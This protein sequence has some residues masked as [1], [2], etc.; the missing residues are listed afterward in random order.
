[1][2]KKFRKQISCILTLIFFAGCTVGPDFLKPEPPK[3]DRYTSGPELKSTI[4][5]DGK[6]Q[7][8]EKGAEVTSEWWS[9]FNSPKLNEIVKTAIQKNPNLEAAQASLRQSQDFLRAGYGVFYPHL[10]ADFQATRQ[11]FSEARFGRGPSSKTFNLYTLT[12]TISY[13]LDIFGGQRR[14][15]ESLKANVD[16]EGYT[17]LGTYLTLTA[18]VVNT[19]IARAAY[20]EEI[21]ATE[22]IINIEKEETLLTEVQA[23]AGTV[24]Y[25]NV[26]GLQSQV[27]ATE[28]TLPGLHQKAEQADHLLSTLTG[29]LPVEWTAPE[30]LLSEINLP[31]NLPLSLPSL[32][33]RQRPDVL[34]AEARLHSASAQ[35]GVA[36]AAML[37]SF[38]INGSYGLVATA[39]NDLFKSSSEIWSIG[40][41]ISAPLFHGGELLNKKRAAVENYNFYLASYRQTVLAAFAQVADVLAALE[42]DA[43][44]LDAQARALKSSEESVRIIRTNYQAGIVNYLQVI[45]AYDQYIRAKIAFLQT[46]AQ[47]LQD[48]VALYVALGGGWWNAPGKNPQGIFDS[49][50]EKKD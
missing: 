24:P 19:L 2:I 16:T 5:A 9:F 22:E 43:E 47:R 15:V 18:N 26:L 11:K 13:A 28:A 7:R 4:T 46:R 6:A 1:M 3:V 39:L 25:L 40:G 37:P 35:I 10:D 44:A 17:V 50:L 12:G 48:T 23:Q 33:V 49:V 29:R 14:S 20:R 42:Y 45:T 36:T 30:I 41:D 21:K 34:A 31:E 27:A 32:L 8:F 38:T